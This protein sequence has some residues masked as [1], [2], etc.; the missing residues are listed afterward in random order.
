LVERHEPIFGIS[1]DLAQNHLHP[2]V[3]RETQ[4]SAKPNDPSTE[5]SGFVFHHV[6]HVASAASA[7]HEGH[8][9]SRFRTR[10][11]CIAQL[12]DVITIHDP[13]YY[14]RDWRARFV[15]TLRNDVRLEDYVCGEPHRDISGVAGVRRP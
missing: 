2:R 4:R 1:D 12:E 8:P 3:L 9:A 13:D 5:P 11:T 7:P 14:S 10:A 6:T 15:Y